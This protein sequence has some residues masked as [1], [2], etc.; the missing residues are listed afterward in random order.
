M[1]VESTETNYPSNILFKWIRCFNS[2]IVLPTCLQ[3]LILQEA[4]GTAAQ[5]NEKLKRTEF[6]AKNSNFFIFSLNVENR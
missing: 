2:K 3:N 6:D 1:K 5:I 4:F